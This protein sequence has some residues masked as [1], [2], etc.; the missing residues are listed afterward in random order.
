MFRK[1]VPDWLIVVFFMSAAVV[2]Y[3]L[4][5]QFVMWLANALATL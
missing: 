2:V 3:L 1:R 4:L 5:A